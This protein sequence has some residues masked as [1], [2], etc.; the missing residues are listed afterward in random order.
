[1]PQQTEV[2]KDFPASV[3]EIVLSGCQNH[4]W[5]LRPFYNRTKEK[6]YAVSDMME[7][8][9]DHY[10]CQNVATENC[11]EGSSRE[12]CLQEHFVR[13]GKSCC[14]D[15]PVSGLDPQSDRRNVSVN[16]MKIN[17]E[18]KTNGHYDLA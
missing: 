10:I 2:Q 12:F 15:E 1:M 11:P 9:A 18:D 4:L 17:R 6:K 16:L 7:K 3:R 5:L 8:T 13:L 14:L